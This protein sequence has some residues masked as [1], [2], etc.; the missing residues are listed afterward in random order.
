MFYSASECNWR[1][2]VTG[3]LAGG[4]YL[5]SFPSEATHQPSLC[6]SNHVP[7]SY[8]MRGSSLPAAQNSGHLVIFIKVSSKL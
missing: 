5:V 4:V 1:A 6:S 3:C 2:R 7:K 8:L